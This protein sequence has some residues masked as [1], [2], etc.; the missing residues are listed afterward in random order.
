MRFRRSVCGTSICRSRAAKS[1]RRFRTRRRASSVRSVRLE[2]DLQETHVNREY[3]GEEQ[4]TASR[5]KVWSFVTDPEKVGRCFPDVVDVAV[6]DPT[7]FDAVVHVGVGPVR[8]KFK[9]KVELLPDP[10]RQ[11]LDMKIS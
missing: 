1:G 4:I 2:P 7:H 3:S 10:A 8:G 9:L 11:R 6:Q 5:D